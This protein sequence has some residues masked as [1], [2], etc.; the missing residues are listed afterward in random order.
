[1]TQAIN[2][3][4]SDFSAFYLWRTASHWYITAAS[5]SE[6]RINL[7]LFGTDTLPTPYGSDV[8]VGTVLARLEALNPDSLIIAFC[9][10]RTFPPFSGKLVSNL[11]GRN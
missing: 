5:E 11:S 4:R 3:D 1:M 2:P 6:R 9:G 10:I 8:P 7:D